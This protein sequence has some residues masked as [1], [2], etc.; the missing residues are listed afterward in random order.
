MSLLYHPTIES[1]KFRQVTGNAGI[2]LNNKRFCHEISLTG[3]PKLY[4]LQARTSAGNR[5]RENLWH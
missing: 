3:R 2:I 5:R 4:N 1:Q